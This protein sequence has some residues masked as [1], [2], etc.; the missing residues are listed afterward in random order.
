MLS[1]KKL[2]QSVI[3]SGCFSQKRFIRPIFSL[4][5]NSFLRAVVDVYKDVSIKKKKTKI[6]QRKKTCLSSFQIF[7]RRGTG[8]VNY[9]KQKKQQ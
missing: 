5:D 1:C 9:M 2:A 4:E 7:I 6:C 8:R 3:K